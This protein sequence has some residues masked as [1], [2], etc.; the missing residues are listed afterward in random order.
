MLQRKFRIGYTRAARLMD[1][2]EERGYVG[3]GQ[4][5]KPREVIFAPSSSVVGRPA[6]ATS[7][8]SAEDDDT[9]FE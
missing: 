5:S 8:V 9:D 7:I 6:G 4:G 2:F 3:P 1:L